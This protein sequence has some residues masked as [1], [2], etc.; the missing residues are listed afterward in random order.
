MAGED[1]GPI[2]IWTTCVFGSLAIL[3]VALRLGFRGYRRRLDMS[4]YCILAA[5]LCSISQ[6]CF[7]MI[8]VIS[9]G[10]GKH[11]A[12]ISPSIKNSIVPKQLFFAN[13]VVFKPT[14][15]FTKLSLCLVYAQLFKRA[16]ST[17]VRITRVLVHLTTFVVVGYYVSATLISIF[18]CNPIRKSYLSKTPGACI[19]LTQFRFS[20]HAVNIATS[21]MVICIPLPA[22]FKMKDKR[23][24]IKQLLFLILLGFVESANSHTSC[25]ITRLVFQF[26]PDPLAKKDPQW[27]N[28]IPNTISMV[29][30]D[31][32]IIAASLVV[33]RPCFQF[34]YNVAT[35]RSN[36]ELLRTTRT[37]GGYH[38]GSKLSSF[39]GGGGAMSSVL[40][41]DKKIS[42]VVDFEME[43]RLVGESRR[44]S[45]ADGDDGYVRDGFGGV[46]AAGA[47]PAVIEYEVWGAARQ[48]RRTMI[49]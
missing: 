29:E 38:T 42:K 48:K 28:T 4:D 22:L 27:A 39:G 41:R 47:G 31:V 37:G 10:Y 40:R 15:L 12:D 32:G 5:L 17:T 7:N 20:G 9:Y 19:D 25:A 14:Y 44:G 36:D 3:L 11:A 49:A 33:M 30:M 6:E 21:I 8:A 23:P 18:Q 35:G 2:L 26:F 13:M 45:A 46:A 34:L 24:E 43:S 1:R 16:D